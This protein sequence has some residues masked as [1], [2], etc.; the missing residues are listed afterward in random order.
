MAHR[1]IIVWLY[2]NTGRSVFAAAL[3]HTM[4]NLTWQLFPNHGSHYDPRITGPVLALTAAIIIARSGKA[5]EPQRASV[6][7]N[8]ATR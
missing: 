5:A 1:V 7:G 4:G 3:Y 2:N 6:I 8:G